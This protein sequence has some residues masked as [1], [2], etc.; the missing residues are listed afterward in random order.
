[1]HTEDLIVDFKQN[2]LAIRAMTTHNTPM[3]YFPP[4][5]SLY[6]TGTQVP[7]GFGDDKDDEG[8]Q[9]YHSNDKVPASPKAYN[10]EDSQLNPL[11]Q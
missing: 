10:L 8:A 7:G 11:V 6:A 9:G 2:A 1:M 3:P 4:F 5:L